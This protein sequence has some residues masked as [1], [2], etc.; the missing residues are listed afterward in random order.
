MT[1]A[2]RPWRWLGSRELAA[3][4]AC[5]ETVVHAWGENWF[6]LPATLGEIARMD[7]TATLG[8]ELDE[9]SARC[10]AAMRI[11]ATAGH[12]VARRALQMPVPGE[13]AETTGVR[14]LAGLQSV[15]M[16]DLAMRLADAFSFESRGM[17]SASAITDLP[18][19]V[20]EGGVR[21]T[22]EVGEMRLLRAQ[23]GL[24][25]F[26]AAPEAP[27]KRSGRT[28]LATPVEALG[29][30]TIA[31]DAVLACVRLPLAQIAD[32]EPGDVIELDCLL[33]APAALRVAGTSECIAHGHLRRNARHLALQLDAA[34]GSAADLLQQATS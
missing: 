20:P 24:T 5:A 26:P 25:M 28:A 30:T 21:M 27:S 4:H 14:L 23:L 18:R 3:V 15:V 6:G 29:R 11:C 2:A 32:M 17:A 9:Y 19:R 33:D 7:P 22:V 34:G 16:D 31:L 12:A 10:D 1:A 8:V 13:P